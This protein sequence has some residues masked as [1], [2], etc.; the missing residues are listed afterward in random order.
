M[1]LCC[2]NSFVGVI[3][4]SL[5]TVTKENREKIPHH[6]FDWSVSILD[7]ILM[8]SSFRRYKHISLFA[9][10]FGALRLQLRILWMLKIEYY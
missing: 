3:T 8:V 4:L 1:D 6:D 9:Y 2:S 7:D 5:S 10:R